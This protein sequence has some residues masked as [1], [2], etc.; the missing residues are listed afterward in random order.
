MK[1]CPDHLIRIYSIVFKINEF[2]SLQIN[3]TKISRHNNNGVYRSS[4][5]LV[6][7]WDPG[8]YSRSRGTARKS[9]RKLTGSFTRFL[10]PSTRCSS[11]KVISQR[12]RDYTSPLPFYHCHSDGIFHANQ[13]FVDFG[14]SLL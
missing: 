1:K 12:C 13:S 14:I 5:Q 9:T 11:N 2:I 4:R 7:S 6:G 8:Y 3:D 10:V